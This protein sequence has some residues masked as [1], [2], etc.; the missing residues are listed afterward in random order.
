MRL[1]LQLHVAMTT[2][3]HPEYCIVHHASHLYTAVRL[4][5]SCMPMMLGLL[6][7]CLSHEPAVGHAAMRGGEGH[8]SKQTGR[9]LKVQQKADG[10]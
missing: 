4:E 9:K 10:A 7:A 3:Q 1:I 6:V 5:G 8:C 2:Q